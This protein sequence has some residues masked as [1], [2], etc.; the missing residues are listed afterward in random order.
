MARRLAQR[1]ANVFPKVHHHAQR[2]H[3]SG[4]RSSSVCAR[5][6]IRRW[7]RRARGPFWADGSWEINEDIGHLIGLSP[8]PD[9]RRRHCRNAI[10]GFLAEA[11]WGGYAGMFYSR[12]QTWYPAHRHALPSY[13]THRL[14]TWA[15]TT[16]EAASHLF[17]S[18]RTPPAR[19]RPGEP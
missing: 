11:V 6:F 13:L 4:R 19:P 8:A 5:N 17:L 2:S 9:A 15:V 12:D 1:R 14:V 7:L 16:L 3:R 10:I 18:E